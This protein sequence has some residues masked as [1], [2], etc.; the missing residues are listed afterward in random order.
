MLNFVLILLIILEIFLTI[1][2]VRKLLEYNKKI[3]VLNNE[4]KLYGDLFLR[5]LIQFRKSIKKINKVV[6]FI[7]N[8]KF[9]RIKKIVSLVF[10]AIQ[11]IILIRS[12]KYK[13]GLKFNFENLKKL[14]FSLLFFCGFSRIYY[15]WTP[16]MF[17][18]VRLFEMVKLIDTII[19][20]PT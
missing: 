1:Y 4:L 19:C 11:I 7:T 3:V 14:F 10:E 2:C 12:F 6:F 20:C 13:K 9:L 17:A 5:K 18:T 15:P 16:L 8:E